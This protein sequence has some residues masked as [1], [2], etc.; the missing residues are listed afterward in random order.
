MATF[1]Y[2]IL[3]DE[4]FDFS[5]FLNRVIHFNASGPFYYVLLY[6]QLLFL[7]PL[8][9]YLFKKTDSCKYGI[10]IE[11]VGVIIVI[12]LSCWTTNHTNILDVYGGG[13]KLFGGTYLILLY[14]G[15]MFGKYYSKLKFNKVGSIIAFTI[16]LLLTI[17]WWNFISVD[18]LKLDSYLPFGGGFNPPGVSLGLYA[19]LIA[20]TV[21][22][23]EQVLG[24]LE[25]PL[26]VFRKIS[27]LGKHT[28]YIF[29]YHH[30]FIDFLPI[31]FEKTG[32]EIN[33]I[34]LMRL[35]YFGCMIWGSIVIEMVMKTMN[36][37]FY[38]AYVLH[39]RY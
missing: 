32:I 28:L 4:G 26:I 3:F 18:M 12:L 37:L 24:Y 35:I 25:S 31:F 10:I 17:L 27:T 6:L 7:I 29:L 9:Y 30:L 2:G 36:M 16:C 15:M 39:T 14:L 19:I 20:S 5:T 34:W 11:M 8:I 22:T 38:K 23:L 1:V 21:L 33:N 13:G